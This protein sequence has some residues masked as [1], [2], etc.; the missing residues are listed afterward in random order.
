VARKWFGAVARIPNWPHK[1]TCAAVAI[2]FR[3]GETKEGI[4][5]G[6]GGCGGG[7]NR[8]GD[9]VHRYC[10]GA[11]TTSEFCEHVVAWWNRRASSLTSQ[12]IC[13]E[14]PSVTYN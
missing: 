12:N 6:D 7:V 1:L 3:H 9:G 11:N 14:R 5:G 8:H 13:H 10:H 2:N 4:D